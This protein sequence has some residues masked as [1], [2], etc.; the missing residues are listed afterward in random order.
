MRLALP[1]LLE[2]VKFSCV[3]M[4][5]PEKALTGVI[6]KIMEGPTRSEAQI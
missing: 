3:F 6:S 2:L 1:L 4:F 5:V